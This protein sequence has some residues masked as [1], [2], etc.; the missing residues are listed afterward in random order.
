MEIYNLVQGTRRSVVFCLLSASRAEEVHGN[1]RLPLTPPFV[2]K[3]TELRINVLLDG[4]LSP[5]NSN[6]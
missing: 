1:D 4:F 3:E 6:L 2:N 5:L